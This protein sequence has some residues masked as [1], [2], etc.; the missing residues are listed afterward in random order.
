[1]APAGPPARHTLEGMPFAIQY[2]EFGGPEVLQLREVDA[3]PLNSGEVRVAVRAAGVNPIDTKI[4]SGRRASA[5]L[6]GHRGIGLDAAGVVAELGDGVEGWAVG[7]PVV[8]SGAKGAY[9]SE[10][11]IDASKLTRMPDGISFEVGA[12]LPVPVGTA[13]Q[14]LR[15]L[16]VGEGTTVLIHGGSGAVGQAAVQFA[17]AWGAS[18]IATA[19]PANHDRLRELG[20]TPVAYGDGLVDRIRL[21][22]PQGIDRV[23]D[24]AG[25]DEALDASFALVEDRSKIGTIVVG[26]KAAQLGIRAWSGG[27]PIPLTDAEQAL[28]FAAVGIAL[29]LISSGSFEVEIARSYP[30]DEAVRA[31]RASEAGELR[32]KIVLIP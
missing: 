13:Y 8:A 2:T 25:T 28:R 1:M 14:V 19:S 24:A 12:A 11:V 31:H 17:R 23:L 7:D 9:A 32:G 4:R 21:A 6:D 22:A 3:P 18:V 20:A 29:D 30:L 15:S 5:P 26:A 10:I 27:N 16:E